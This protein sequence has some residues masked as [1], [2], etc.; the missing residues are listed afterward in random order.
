MPPVKQKGNSHQDQIFLIGLSVFGAINSE[1]ALCC[2][3]DTA[4]LKRRPKPDSPVFSGKHKFCL[5]FWV[6]K[7]KIGRPSWLIGSWS[8]SQ[9]A[10]QKRKGKGWVVFKNLWAQDSST[11]Y[12]WISVSC[13]IVFSILLFF[14]NPS[15]FWQ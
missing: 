8:E 2:F 9:P 6:V 15:L 11:R 14:L 3:W 10:H 12:R 13:L 5:V 1:Q 4:Q 7:R